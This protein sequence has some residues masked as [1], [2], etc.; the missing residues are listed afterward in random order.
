MTLCIRIEINKQFLTD[1]FVQ[2]L[3]ETLPGKLHGNNF[4]CYKDYNIK[5]SHIV[6][7]TKAFSNY[8]EKRVTYKM[9]HELIH[10]FRVSQ[11]FRHV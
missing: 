4:L 7:G 2:G 10:V 8:D 6:G 3:N 5:Y 1:Y 11:T 9:H